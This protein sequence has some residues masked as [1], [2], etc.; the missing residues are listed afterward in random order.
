VSREEFSFVSSDGLEIAYYGWRAPARAAGIVQVAHGMGE[1]ALRYAHVADFLNRSGY[2]VYASDHRG[3]GRTAKN[4]ESLGDFGAAGWD[5]LV[6]DL[7]MV[8]KLAG[9]R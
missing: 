2:H 3:H 9:S 7:V 1:H 5:G 4:V 6:G 8:T